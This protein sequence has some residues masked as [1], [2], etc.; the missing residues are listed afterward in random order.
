[1][2]IPSWSSIMCVSLCLP[3]W[4]FFS[5]LLVCLL[6]V[7]ACARV[8]LC[9]CVRMYHS[10]GLSLSLWL[11]PFYCLQYRCCHLSFILN[12]RMSDLLKLDQILSLQPAIAFAIR[13]QLYEVRILLRILS[14]LLSYMLLW[15]SWE[16]FFFSLLSLVFSLLDCNSKRNFSTRKQNKQEGSQRNWTFSTQVWL[17][18]FEF[19]LLLVLFSNAQ[20]LINQTYDY[21]DFKQH[22]YVCSL[23][24]SLSVRLVALDW[25]WWSYMVSDQV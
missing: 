1:M 6:S 11:L 9:A 21:K 12:C 8:Y 5:V 25:I 24:L 16:R 13:E 17:F 15:T 18:C 23:S 7:C 10:C 14:I 19:L 4:F 3:A 22:F 20:S 2:R